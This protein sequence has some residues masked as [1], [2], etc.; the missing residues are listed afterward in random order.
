MIIDQKCDV[1]I[2]IMCN[3][4]PKI[5]CPNCVH[6]KMSRSEILMVRLVYECI[7]DFDDD[8]K[9][10]DISIMLNGTH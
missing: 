8:E 4:Y 3:V 6:T 9:Y 1:N 7:Y 5:S 10:R 2:F